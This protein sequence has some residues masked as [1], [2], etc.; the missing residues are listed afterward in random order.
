MSHT[1]QSAFSN[2]MNQYGEQAQQEKLAEARA[3][4][5]AETFR[6]VRRIAFLLVILGAF[7]AAAYY[8]NEVTAKVS[9][10]M[11]KSFFK[12]PYAEAEG[13]TKSK[14]ADIQAHAEKNLQV[15]ESTYK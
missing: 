8:H 12:S 14:V 9:Q 13:K 3:E 11:E 6:H 10:V 1:T 4:K 5:R 2:L 7:G 15:I